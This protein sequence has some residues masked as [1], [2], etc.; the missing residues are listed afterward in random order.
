MR[1]KMT[2]EFGRQAPHFRVLF[3]TNLIVNFL[4]LVFFSLVGRFEPVETNS[5]LTNPIGVVTLS[6]TVTVSV[7]IIYGVVLF[8][9]LLLKYYI[10]NDRERIYL[11]PEGRTTIFLS[12]LFSLIG[13]FLISFFPAVLIESLLF[14]W[15]SNFIGLLPVNVIFYLFNIF[16]LVG[17]SVVV[18]VIIILVSLLIGQMVQSTNSSIIYSVITVSII[19]NLIAQ[20]YQVNTIVIFVLFLIAIVSMLMLVKIMQKKIQNDDVIEF[21]SGNSH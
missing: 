20:L 2:Y 10:K 21:S 13:H 7:A 1:K 5:I 6:M 16:G 4:S 17:F 3:W 14:Y 11:F 12:K 8:N 15:L 19:G 9:R 18:A